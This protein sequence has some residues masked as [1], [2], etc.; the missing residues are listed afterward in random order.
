MKFYIKP[1]QIT[2]QEKT[3]EQISYESMFK[4]TAQKRFSENYFT[5]FLKK[6]IRY[7]VLS[8]NSHSYL[9]KD[10]FNFSLLNLSFI[11]YS[12]HFEL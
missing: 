7:K 11:S 12:F 5:N 4:L 9:N 6:K 3:Y 10:K 8:S 2:Y 1:P